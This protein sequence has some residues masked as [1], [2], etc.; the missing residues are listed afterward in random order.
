M[1]WTRVNG[2]LTITSRQ[3][4]GYTYRTRQSDSNYVTLIAEGG[5]SDKKP[6]KRERCK[7]LDEAYRL[8]EKWESGVEMPERHRVSGPYHIVNTFSGKHV[9]PFTTE[10]DCLMAK[11]IATPDWTNGKVLNQKDFEEHM[12]EI[13]E[14]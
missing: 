13:S 10:L 14:S 3:R 6:V 2:S 12:R 4:S 1:E 7:T 9:G 5:I 8:A 11:S